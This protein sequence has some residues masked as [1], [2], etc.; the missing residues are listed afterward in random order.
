[1]NLGYG[2]DSV[3]NYSRQERNPRREDGEK[4]K[5]RR[6]CANIFMCR[7]RQFLSSIFIDEKY[8]FVFDEPVWPSGRR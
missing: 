7:L 3:R 4:I 5:A 8:L 1:M 6:N 2:H